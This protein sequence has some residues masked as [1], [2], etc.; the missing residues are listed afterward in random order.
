M[1]RKRKYAG[2]LF[3]GGSSILRHLFFTDFIYDRPENPEHKD[4]RHDNRDQLCDRECPPDQVDI[5]ELRQKISNRQQCNQLSCDRD[6]HTV[7]CFAERLENAA[8][9][10]A[11]SCEDKA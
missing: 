4:D 1:L 11:E 10:D 6:K 9:G 7:D 3:L 8:A 2:A 5:A